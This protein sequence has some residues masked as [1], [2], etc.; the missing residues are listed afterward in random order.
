MS[1]K[2]DN[3]LDE[4]VLDHKATSK[5]GILERIFTLGLSEKVLPDSQ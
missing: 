3:L 2:N 1:A 4:A 5:R